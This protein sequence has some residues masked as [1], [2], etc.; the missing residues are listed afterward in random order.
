[1][2]EI[3]WNH[4][5]VAV[6]EKEHWQERLTYC[7]SSPLSLALMWTAAAFSQFSGSGFRSKI[8]KISLSFQFLGLIFPKK[9][10]NFWAKILTYSVQWS[11]EICLQT[12]GLAFGPTKSVTMYITTYA[13]MLGRFCWCQSTYNWNQSHFHSSIR[14]RGTSIYSIISL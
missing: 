1:M 14:S 3:D 5:P 6:H 4:T 13:S 12:H 7:A 11:F 8:C 10:F 2:R 9:A